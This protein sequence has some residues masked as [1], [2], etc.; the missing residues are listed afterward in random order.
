M[1]DKPKPTAK[2]D[3]DRSAKFGARLAKIEAAIANSDPSALLLQMQAQLN[4]ALSMLE[5]LREDVPRFAAQIPQ[6]LKSEEVAALLR[7]NPSA[8]LISLNHYGP[9]G[10]KPGDAFEP[11]TKFKTPGQFVSLVEGGH[12]KVSRAAA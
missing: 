4:T 2:P 1:A 3:E 6:A 8:R 11:R 12:I 5:E 7:A 10:L 9:S